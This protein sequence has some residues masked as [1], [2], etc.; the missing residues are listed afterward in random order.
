MNG[1]KKTRLLLGAAATGLALVA[2]F[3][4]WAQ[5][6]AATPSVSVESGTAAPNEEV[7]VAVSANVPDG[8]G[9]WTLDIS[10]DTSVVTPTSCDG[11]PANSVCNTAFATDAVRVTGA[12][13]NGI[14]G[15]KVLGHITFKCGTSTGTSPLTI[16]LNVLADAT[17]GNPA[18]ISAGAEVNSGSIDCAVPVPATTAPTALPPTGAF[19]GGSGGSS[20]MGWIL[21]ALSMAGLAAVAGL[22]ALRLRAR[23]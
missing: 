1:F 2:G 17:I 18:D 5:V 3:L 19:D 15:E 13:A 14:R 11:D 16:T 20:N 12:S 23:R 22:G 10:Y 9:A 7:T 8:L 6:S 4:L 21:A